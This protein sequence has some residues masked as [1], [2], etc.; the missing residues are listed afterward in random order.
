MNATDGLSRFNGIAWVNHG[1]EE[2]PLR[3]VDIPRQV[4]AVEDY[5]F[6]KS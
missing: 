5:C 3:R 1:F 6:L 4:A 2:T